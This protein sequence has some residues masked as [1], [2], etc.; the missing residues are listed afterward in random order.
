MSV[1]GD[2]VAFNAGVL[3]ALNG[4][5]NL[6]TDT[7]KLGLVTIAVTPAATTAGPCWGAGGSTNL[8][9]NQ[10][11]PGGNYATGGPEIASTAVT[12]AAGV[13][14]FD[15]DDVTIAQDASNPATARWGIIYSDTAT[16]KDAFAYVDLGGVTDLSSGAFTLT[17]PVAGIW[18]L[19]LAA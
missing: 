2:I 6:E 13:I 17:L 19:A 7:F 16:N 1:Q 18:S 8:A 4:T 9:T 3:A 15:G 5:I 10:C 14:M 12:E 11:T